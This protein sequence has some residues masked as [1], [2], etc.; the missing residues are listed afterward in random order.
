MTPLNAAFGQQD[1]F[2]YGDFSV[3]NLI[4]M[5]ADIVNSYQVL[6]Y[7]KHTPGIIQ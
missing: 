6:K 7:R 1:S 3:C 5:C 4:I 2:T